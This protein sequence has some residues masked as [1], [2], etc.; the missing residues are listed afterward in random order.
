MRSR[1]ALLVIDVQ[2]DF[3]G[4]GAL[5]VPEGDQVVPVLNNYIELFARSNLPVFASRDWHPLKTRHFNTCGGLWPAHC[6]QNTHGARFHPDLQLP[7]DTVIISSGMNP[8]EDGYSAFDAVDA[9]GTAL[10]GLLKQRGVEELYAGGLATDYCVKCTVLDALKAGYAVTLLTDAVRGVDVTAGDAQ[11]AVDEMVRC[12]AGTVAFE[13][14]L[15][16][17]SQ[18]KTGA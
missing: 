11:K 3:C 9:G 16:D 8:D 15:K 6:V 13:R 14:F 4:G 17:F 1:K 5:E 7:P 12:G 10:N 18:Q 2:N